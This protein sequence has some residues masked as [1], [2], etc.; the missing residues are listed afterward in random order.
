MNG[1]TT[2]EYTEPADLKRPDRQL[3]SGTF[4]FQA[5]D[6]KSVVHFRNIRVKVLP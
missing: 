1:T 3:E 4:A 2:V 6:P 5:H